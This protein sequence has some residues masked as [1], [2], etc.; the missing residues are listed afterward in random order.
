MLGKYNAVINV[1]LQIVVFV[2]SQNPLLV[3]KINS[4]RSKTSLTSSARV[5]T[6]QEAHQSRRFR[7]ANLLR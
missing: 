2:V 7:A 3:S 1:A 6:Q 4:R 5:K